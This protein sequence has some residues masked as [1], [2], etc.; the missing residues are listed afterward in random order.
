M[1]SIQAALTNVAPRL[2]SKTQ[3]TIAPLTVQCFP[4]ISHLARP[5]GCGH[6]HKLSEPGWQV[7]QIQPAPKSGFSS[8]CIGQKAGP[9]AECCQ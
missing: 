8:K 7:N 1:V 2:N 9:G 4:F 6:L 3:M 5:R